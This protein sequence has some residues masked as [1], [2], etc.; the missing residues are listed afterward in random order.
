MTETSDDRT[1]GWPDEPSNDELARLADELRRGRPELPEA[2]L[3]QVGQRLDRELTRAGSRWQRG[4]VLRAALAAGLLLAGG[5]GYWFS[6]RTAPEP[7]PPGPGPV[8]VEPAHVEDHFTV[9]LAGPRPPEPP[10]R[11]LLRLDE[12]QSLFTN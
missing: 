8:A 4:L 9:R 3:A 5:V 6:T 1:E 2:A 10:E 7:A 12:H 11:P